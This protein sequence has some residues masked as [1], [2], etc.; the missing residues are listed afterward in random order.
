V[1][2]SPVARPGRPEVGQHRQHRKEPRQEVAAGA[3]PGHGLRAEGVE[4]EE[5]G[6]EARAQAIRR[7]VGNRRP[8]PTPGEQPEREDVD[9]DGRRRV[10]DEARQVV[11]GRGHAPEQVVDAPGHPRHRLVEPGEGR[12]P[13]PAELGRAESPVVQVRLELVDVVP[14]QEAVV[15]GGQERDEGRDGDDRGREGAEPGAG[16]RPHGPGAIGS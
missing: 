9:G 8:R 6:R 4:R 3:D 7:P 2:A 11:A 10:E 15:E 14:G 1:R 16:R 5:E 12:R 13:H